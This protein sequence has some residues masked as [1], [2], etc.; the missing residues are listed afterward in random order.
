MHCRA[1][2]VELAIRIDVHANVEVPSGCGCVAGNEADRLSTDLYADV[3]V[4][5]L[6]TIAI[7]ERATGQCLA[8]DHHSHRTILALGYRGRSSG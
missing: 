2:E 3:H 4:V 1:L 8:D 7:A 5:Q 6:A